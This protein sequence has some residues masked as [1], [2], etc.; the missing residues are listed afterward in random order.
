[1]KAIIPIFCS[2]CLTIVAVP[3]VLAENMD[4]G[5]GTH[6]NMQSHGDAQQMSEGVVKKVKANG[7][8]TISH[9]PLANLGMPPMTMTFG[10]K[11]KALLK[12]VKPGDRVRFL[13][14]QSGDSLIVSRLAV[15]H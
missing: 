12:G 2:L 3:S 11:D 15:I 9:G 14:E 8:I 1:M 10:V 6:M 7:M 5:G 4:Q 13:A